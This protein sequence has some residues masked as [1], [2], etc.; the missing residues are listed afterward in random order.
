MK[1]GKILIDKADI[2][3]ERFGKLTVVAYHNCYYSITKGGERLRHE[4]ICKCDCGKY[5]TKQRSP[6][7]NGLTKSCGCLQNKRK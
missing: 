3:G 6:L 4:Y 2:I 5:V 7:I 1:K